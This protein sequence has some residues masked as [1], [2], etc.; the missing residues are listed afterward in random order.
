MARRT[1][2]TGAGPYRGLSPE[3]EKMKA[4]ARNLRP[5]DAVNE[6]AALS[7]L[8]RRRHRS[9][10]PVQ[11]DFRQIILALQEKKIPF[12][13]TGAH[14]ISTWTG[15]PRSTQD[16]DI[17]VKGGRNQARAVKALRALY[18]GL[19]VR[20]FTGVVAFFVP[21]ERESVLDVTYPHRPDI[22]VTLQ[23][24]VWVEDQGLRYRIPSLEA[25]LANKYGAM[26]AA[27]R[28]A[29][30]RA[31]D[32]VDC[33]QMVRHSFDEGRKP[34]DR[35][36]LRIL[37]EMVRPGGGEEMLSLVEQVRSGQVPRIDPPP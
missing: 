6:C 37:G 15:R 8:F 34:I 5:Q 17:L 13:L 22:E 1:T 18:P 19:E 10:S 9:M 20:N 2:Q 30:K 12:V 29:L 23:S 33:Y 35:V 16:V 7:D 27:D 3:W 26:L 11:P 4:S 28:D 31:Q 24:D 21:G 32:A 25:A 36:H 14:G